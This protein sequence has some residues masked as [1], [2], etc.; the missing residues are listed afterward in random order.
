MKKFSSFSCFLSLRV[1]RVEVSLRSAG[2]RR[3]KAREMKSW[4]IKTDPRLL[5]ISR[6]RA[7]LKHS[8]V[9]PSLRV[10][11]VKFIYR[12]VRG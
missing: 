5:V 4:E 8:K 2:I 3:A 7:F 9:L 11:N 1:M 12:L 10:E 6:S